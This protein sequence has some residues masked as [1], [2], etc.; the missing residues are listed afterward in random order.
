MTAL[1][2]QKILVTGLTGQV[3]FPVAR[4]LAEAGN[5]VW[6]LARYSARGSRERVEAAGVRPVT[7]DLVE[8]DF[9]DV[10]DDFDYVLN[11][12]VLHA[13][14]FQTALAA[15]AEGA[16]LLMAHCRGARAFL[17]CSSTAVYQP[18]GHHAFA[19]DDPLGDNHRPA[20]MVTYS[21]SKIAAEAVVRAFGRHLG[22]A[23]TIARLNVPYG[24]TWGWPRMMLDWMLAGSD[25]YVHTDAPT[26]YNPI[27][28][29]DIV[30]TI[31]A[32]LDAAAVPATVVNW[33]GPETV[34]AEEWC[35]Y[36]G[37]MVGVE[38]KLNASEYAIAS[39]AT[40]IT[41]MRSLVGEPKV[42]WQEG[43]RR[44]VETSYP[45]RVKTA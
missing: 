2:G 6:G 37:R 21:I 8:A 26:L 4:R 14:D 36:M 3:G 38:P 16:G 12:A 13:P 27:H 7:A 39:V 41:K 11:F 24:D 20:G 29:D 45:D 32:L 18:S 43:F 28:E 15:N 25:V 42:G 1:T 10:P 40:D 9:S 33:A 30:A 22:V 44:L 35:A 17:H 23:T 5:E 34:G 19:E 31:P